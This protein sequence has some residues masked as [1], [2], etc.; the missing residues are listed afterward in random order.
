VLV[1]VLILKR[2]PAV[3]S[4]GRWFYLAGVSKYGGLHNTVNE[5]WI[6][7]DSIFGSH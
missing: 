3:G 1:L 4:G 2:A 5:Q 6:V 7:T